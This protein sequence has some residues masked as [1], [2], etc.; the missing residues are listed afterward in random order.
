VRGLFSSPPHPYLLPTGEK[1]KEEKSL[2]P[3]C[4]FFSPRPDGR[5]SANVSVA[6]R[7]VRR[8]RRGRVRGIG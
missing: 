7:P 4:Y 8:R 3:L 2:S 6:E 5:K 1:E